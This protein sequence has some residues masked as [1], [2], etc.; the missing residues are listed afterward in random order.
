MYCEEVDFSELSQIKLN[1]QSSK[2]LEQ[3]FLES[4]YETF[5]K[6]YPEPE[7]ALRFLADRYFF[8]AEFKK[9]VQVLEQLVRLDSENPH[10]YFRLACLYSC[11]KMK[12]KAFQSL[13]SAI[14]LGFQDKERL[15]N[16]EALNFLRED[17]TFKVLLDKL[18]S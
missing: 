6:I 2:R 9:G 8:K 11:L 1:P 12:D 10:H 16:E 15:E 13:E 14:T 7:V 18:S 4:F 5:W 17:D 3:D